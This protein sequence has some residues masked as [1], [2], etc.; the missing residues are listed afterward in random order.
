LTRSCRC[1]WR[2]RWRTRSATCWSRSSTGG[3][4]WCLCFLFGGGGVS[5]WDRLAVLVVWLLLQCQYLG[6]RGLWF[7][8]CF[9]QP[10][11]L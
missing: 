7:M 1:S 9:K 3:D 5:R 8:Y 6:G 4:I 11:S 2:P 10:P